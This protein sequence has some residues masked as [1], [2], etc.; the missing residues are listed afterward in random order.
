MYYVP[1]THVNPQLTLFHHVYP[2]EIQFRNVLPRLLLFTLGYP[3]L[4]ESMFCLN[5]T[6]LKRIRVV[7]SER[8]NLEKTIFSI[9]FLTWNRHHLWPYYA[10]T[11]AIASQISADVRRGHAIVSVL[12]RLAEKKRHGHVCNKFI[13]KKLHDHLSYSRTKITF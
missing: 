2:C 12:S 6:P 1:R 9:H 3:L 8:R 13:L 10:R 5:R 11:A 7:I 4:L